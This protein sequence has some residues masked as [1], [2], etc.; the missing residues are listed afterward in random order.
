MRLKI[1]WHA[2]PLLVRTEHSCPFDTSRDLFAGH[3]GALINDGRSQCKAANVHDDNGVHHL[4]VALEEG[5]VHEGKRERG[6]SKGKER[7]SKGKGSSSFECEL[8]KCIEACSTLCS[9]RLV[10]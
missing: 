6:T 2:L 9:S 8:F 10:V 5:Y 3:I 4:Y 7:G 1:R